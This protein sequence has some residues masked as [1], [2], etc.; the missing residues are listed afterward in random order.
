MPAN[1]LAGLDLVGGLLMGLLLMLLIV[2][3]RFLVAYARV[4]D[5]RD[6]LSTATAITGRWTLGLILGGA[7]A[8]AVGLVQFGDIV[9]MTVGFI[10]GHPY[11]VTNFGILGLGGAGLS[12]LI[13]ISGQQFV[14]AGMVIVGAVFLTVEVDDAV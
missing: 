7:S 4:R 5:R 13:S 11:F 9:G 1:I 10:V 8:A 2:L 12:G 3:G 14:G 6:A